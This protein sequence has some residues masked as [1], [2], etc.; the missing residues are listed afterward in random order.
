MEENMNTAMEFVE[1]EATG[2]MSTSDM[3]KV[4]G[5][6]AGGA[7]L[8]GAAINVGIKLWKTYKKGKEAQ[9]REAE[10]EYENAD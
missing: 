8:I 10:Y 5:I 7:L 6:A 3:L 9:A 2:G 4:G 1:S